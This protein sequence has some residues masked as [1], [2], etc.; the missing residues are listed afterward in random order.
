MT[1]ELYK[2]REHELQK[3]AQSKFSEIKQIQID[4]DLGWFPIWDT[5]NPLV[6]A[7]D[8]Y[9]L[10]IAKILINI[11]IKPPRYYDGIVEDYAVYTYYIYTAGIGLG[12]IPI[13]YKE[14]CDTW[15]KYIRPT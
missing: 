9:G 7:I 4:D 5:D 10:P 12:T 15:L 1:Y 13:K 2:S 14:L 6:K 8:N 3:Q 11:K